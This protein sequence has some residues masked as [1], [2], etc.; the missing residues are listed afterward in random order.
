M[1][2]SIFVSVALL[3]LCAFA[4]AQS[5]VWDKMIQAAKK[6][7]IVAISNLYY[8]PE[9]A[10][11]MVNT[12]TDGHAIK[13][14]MISTTGPSAN[15]RYVPD[16]YKDAKASMPLA[17]LKALLKKG[18]KPMDGPV[19]LG[20]GKSYYAIVVVDGNRRTT[21]WVDPETYLPYSIRDEEWKEY[22]WSPIS[23]QTFEYLKA[24]PPTKH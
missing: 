19:V 14:E 22:Y 23:Y 16:I 4:Q 10:R 3:G 18:Q 12:W 7:R 21:I 9:G 11:G 5:E 13:Q 8:V 15:A 2:V 1:R 20:D 6:V 24:M 17:Q